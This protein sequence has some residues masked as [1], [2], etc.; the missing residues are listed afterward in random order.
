MDKYGHSQLTAADIAAH[1]GGPSGLTP[2]DKPIDEAGFDLTTRIWLVSQKDGSGYAD[3]DGRKYHFPTHIHNGQQVQAGDLVFCYRTLDSKETD[4]GCLFGVGRVSRREDKSDGKEADIYFDPFI[5]FAPSIP[6]K[7]VGDP[8]SG[9][10]NSIEAV[11]AAWAADVLRVAGLRVPPRADI[12]RLTVNDVNIELDRLGLFLDTRLVAQAVAALRAGKHVMLSGPPGTG[13]T[14]FGEALASAAQRVGICAG[15]LP[16]TATAD[17]TSSDTV[18]TYRLRPPD[19]LEFRPGQLLQSIDEDR[20]I[21]IDELN[22]A[23]IDKAIGQWFTVLSGQ[24]VVLPFLEERDGQLLPPSIVPPGAD[25][26]PRCHAHH[27][28]HNWRMIATLN[29]RD[30]DLLFD[31]S[32]ALLRRFAVIEV[33]PPSE[34]L[35]VEILAARAKI[36]HADLDKA[37][38]KVSQLPRQ[39]GPAILIDCAAFMRSR[40]TVAKESAESIS[41]GDVLD[42]ALSCYIQ[43]HLENVTEGKT[44]LEKALA[45]LR[46]EVLKGTSADAPIDEAADASVDEGVEDET[47]ADVPEVG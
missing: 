10:R 14:K 7:S 44:Q 37:L 8:R 9:A 24:S 45:S 47:D 33:A 30:R 31:M 11:S 13:K 40:L 2:P 21:V 41:P 39:L 35:W 19:V 16:A 28:P 46:A 26:P 32:E 36:N 3:E 29:D 22:R 5:A 34:E 43:P 1:F 38:L 42:E 20:W 4:K 23:D 27:V 25:A 6:L 15:A 18:G 17:W 12:S